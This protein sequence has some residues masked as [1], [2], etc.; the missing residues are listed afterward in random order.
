MQF[1]LSS[2]ILSPFNALTAAVAFAEDVI[3][4]LPTSTEA[5]QVAKKVLDAFRARHAALFA[6]HALELEIIK[7][8]LIGRHDSSL[9]NQIAAI[10]AILAL[11]YLAP[12]KTADFVAGVARRQNQANKGAYEK[13]V[14]RQFSYLSELLK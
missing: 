5:Y 8:G 1:V 13:I 7:G 4:A 3:T 9:A 10:D 11:I 6:E 14:S 2:G 12:E